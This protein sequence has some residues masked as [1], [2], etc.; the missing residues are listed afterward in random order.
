MTLK[1]ETETNPSTEKPSR[2]TGR[3]LAGA[4][5]RVARSQ[6]SA[7]EKCQAVLTL[8]TEKARPSD[9]CRELKVNYMVLNHWQERALEG[10]LQALSTRVDLGAGQ[11]LSPRLQALLEK[12]Q[13]A[14][15]PKL[16]KRLERMQEEARAARKTE[17]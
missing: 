16:E 12:R 7:Q 5:K 17:G 4:G 10:M 13:A 9:L 3:G 11:V 1:K 14:G 2:P 6:P 8:W 15:V